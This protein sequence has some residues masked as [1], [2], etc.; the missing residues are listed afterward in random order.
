MRSLSFGDERDLVI[1]SML[2][3]LEFLEDQCDPFESAI[4]SRAKES[5]DVKIIMS[6]QGIDFYLAA[7]LSS[8]I[9]DVNRF[10]SDNHL[11]SALGIVPVERQSL[12]CQKDRKNVEGRTFYRLGGHSGQ[13]STMLG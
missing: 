8:Y 10:P 13:Q 5:K 4:R 7:L 11:A 1:K 6:V 12:Q 3:R 2:D 9:G